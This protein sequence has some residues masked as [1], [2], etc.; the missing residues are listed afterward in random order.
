MDED[1]RGVAEPVWLVRL[2]LLLVLIGFAGYA[3]RQAWLLFL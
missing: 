2:V 3:G 1:P